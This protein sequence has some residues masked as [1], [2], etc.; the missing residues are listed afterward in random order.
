MPLTPSFTIS[1]IAG[2][3]SILNFSDNSTG[4]DILVTSRRITLTK[5]DGTTLVTTGTVTAYMAWAL[6]VNPISVDVLTR[7]YALSI[8]VDWLNAAN[9]VLYTLTNTFVFT[10]YSEAFYY[11]LT[12]NQASIPSIIN[13]KNYYRNKMKLRVE[14]DSANQAISYGGD[15]SASQQC[16]DR[17]YLLTSN[18]SLYY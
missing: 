4:S 14:I 1:Q 9:V 3:P 16:L 5:A 11:S 15:L 6:A 8:K 12:Q 10:L 18:Q 2:S 17:A 7:D 13:D